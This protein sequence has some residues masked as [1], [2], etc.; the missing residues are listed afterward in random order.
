MQVKNDT[1]ACSMCIMHTQ[2]WRP[3]SPPSRPGLQL[4]QSCMSL[5][6]A[7][8]KNRKRPKSWVYALPSVNFL[9]EQDFDVCESGPG[10][11]GWGLSGRLGPNE[12]IHNSGLL[13]L[14]TLSPSCLV[15]GDGG[16][17]VHSTWHGR[18]HWGVTWWRTHC[19]VCQES[20][21]TGQ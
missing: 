5:R 2:C 13:C 12:K 6:R 21:H 14:F 10:Q 16:V 8:Q 3:T 18:T 15:H 20:A 9:C 19:R 4:P 7:S 11:G 17:G 1:A